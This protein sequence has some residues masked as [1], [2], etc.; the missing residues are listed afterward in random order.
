M[1]GNPGGNNRASANQ[2]ETQLRGRPGRGVSVVRVDSGGGELS[3]RLAGDSRR[4]EWLIMRDP[5]LGVT[6]DH[7]LGSLGIHHYA[8]G[9]GVSFASAAEE[10]GHASLPAEIQGGPS[11]SPSQ[12]CCSPFIREG[13][14]MGS[15]YRKTTA[16]FAFTELL[17]ILDHREAGEGPREADC[18]VLWFCHTCTKCQTSRDSS[19][20][21]R[22]A[23]SQHR[24]GLCLTGPAPLAACQGSRKCRGSLLPLFL[25][26][27]KVTKSHLPAVCFCTQAIGSF[28][29]WPPCFLE[30]DQRTFQINS[31]LQ[32]N[33][34]KVSWEEKNCPAHLRQQ[35]LPGPR[36]ALHTRAPSSAHR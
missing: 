26:L 2:R 1:S 6:I 9:P 13:A 34:L 24:A 19:L 3:Q 32:L 31:T 16:G 27:L 8:A 35:M 28:W 20:S 23:L 10:H 30:K 21:E 25:S 12:P 5:E 11:F 7:Y 14:G 22:S 18:L 15:R 36:P 29:T 4:T 33:A 17:C